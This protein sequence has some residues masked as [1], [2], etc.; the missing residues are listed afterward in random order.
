MTWEQGW[1]LLERIAAVVAV[2]SLPYLVIKARQGQPRFSFQL[3]GSYREFFN[4][5]NLDYCRMHFTGTLK[6]HSTKPNSVQRIILVVWSDPKKR[7][8]KRFGFGV[9]RIECEGVDLHEPLLF[10]AKE[11]K[12]LNVDF[13]IPLTGTSDKELVEAFRAIGE[14]MYL[15]Q[16]E[17]ELAFEDTDG[18]LFDQEGIL[19]NRTAIDL[20]WT[21]PNTYQQLTEG[22]MLPFLRHLGKIYWA[23][24]RFTIRKF[25][26]SLGV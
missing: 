8:V 2:V 12:T 3:A 4:R 21:L 1:T 11:G 14:N 5:D 6:N 24:A 20:R 19:R 23:S 10:D 9:S 15:P 26:R 22:R 16:Y 18:H 25:I 7:S 17:Y 13:E